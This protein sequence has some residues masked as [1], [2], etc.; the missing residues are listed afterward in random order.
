MQKKNYKFIYYLTTIS[1]I[2]FSLLAV[3]HFNCFNEPFYTYE[4]NK[5]KLYGKGIAEYIGISNEDLIELTH[6]TLEYLNDE[7]LTLDKQM[8]INGELREVFTDDEKL[9]MVDVR[10]L[11]LT[12]NKVM[13]I[14]GIIFLICLL[15]IIIKKYSFYDYY[16][17]NKKIYKYLLIFFVVLG[18]W[19]LIDFN[20]FWNFFH[21]IFFSGNDLWILD[22][23]KDILIMIVPPEFFFHLVTVVFIS[24]IVVLAIYYYLIKHIGMKERND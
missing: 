18:A 3:V 9:H 2:L 7:S 16:L 5:L 8:F 21:H 20:S 10:K 12:A 1:F 23:R 17:V 13:I 11:N 14:S 24:Y 22:L 15:Y 6:F 19:I 4:H